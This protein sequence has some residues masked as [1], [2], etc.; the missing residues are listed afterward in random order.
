MADINR[1]VNVTTKFRTDGSEQR[2]VRA[3]RDMRRELS[4]IETAQRKRPMRQLSQDL[5]QV[6]TEAKKAEDAVK[7]VATQT[8]RAGR[9]LVTDG[10]LNLGRAGTALRNAPA[11]PIPGTG[12]TT[13][14]ISRVLQGFGEVEI[15]LKQLAIA[16]PLA[17]GALIG[18]A[19]AIKSFNDTV[20][21]SKKV[22]DSVIA[23]RIELA[24]ILRDGTRQEIELKRDQLKEELDDLRAQR[25]EARRLRDE[26]FSTFGG[27]GLGDVPRQII[28]QLTTIRELEGTYNDLNAQTVNLETQYNRLTQALDNNETA[29]QDAAEAER[30]LLAARQAGIDRSVTT[31]LRAESEVRKLNVEQTRERIATLRAENEGIQRVLQAGQVSE[32]KQKE[33]AQT[34]IDNAIA[35]GIF[36][37]ALPDKSR[38]ED[39]A[40]AEAQR[41]QRLEETVGAVRQFN[42]DIAKLT[43]ARAEKEADILADLNDKI[44][45]ITRKAAD[46][47]E[48]EL[49][50]LEQRRQDLGRDLGRD[51]RDARREAELEDL[52]ARIDFQRDEA[53][54]FRDHLRSLRDIREQSQAQEEDLALNRDFAGL[55]RLRRDTNIRLNQESRNFREQRA[56]REL[57]FRDQIEDEQRR[58]AFERESRLLRFNDALEDANIQAQREL[59]QIQRNKQRELNLAQQAANAELNLLSQKY[60]TE[61]QARRGAIQAEL[62]IINQGQQARLQ[63]EAAFQRALLAQ[64]VA[65]QAGLFRGTTNN[66]NASNTFNITSGGTPAQLQ[67]LAYEIDTRI[68]N[69]YGRVVRTAS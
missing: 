16:G 9:G 68:A 6:A 45:D 3:I 42:D 2:S 17:A 29:A 32:E 33:L 28:L 19:L 43:E 24:K 26:V 62:Q 44:V 39:A 5:K 46:D 66:I 64:A 65:I 61:L 4:G 14:P 69:S 48:Q 11:I 23:A 40:E 12:I 63:Q 52:E 47:A 53:R 7:G 15:G 67:Q 30:E 1:N 37:R 22:V 31:Q 21:A 54:S 8:Q 59:Q 58:R 60:N 10:R 55:R 27:G 50:Q 57:A 18:L 25:D 56:E 36:T 51:E 35:L 20:E 49:R 41:A 38:L 13:E 34:L